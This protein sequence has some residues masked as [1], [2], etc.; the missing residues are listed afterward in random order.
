MT[1]PPNPGKSEPEVT[2]CTYHACSLTPFY[3]AYYIYL[4][5]LTVRWLSL[6]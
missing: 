6:H 2:P 3:T 1:N 4:L 5:L